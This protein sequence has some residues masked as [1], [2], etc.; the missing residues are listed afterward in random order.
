MIYH[1]CTKATGA[2]ERVGV[3]NGLLPGVNTGADADRPAAKEFARESA[4]DPRGLARNEAVVK[5]ADRV[6]DLDFG[7]GELNELGVDEPMESMFGTDEI[8]DDSAED[9][10]DDE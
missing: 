8:A 7:F 6:T 2:T 9:E 5:E 3:F 10:R 4:G 1:L